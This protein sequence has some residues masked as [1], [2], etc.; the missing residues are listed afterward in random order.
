MARGEVAAAIEQKLRTGLAPDHIDIVDDSE[1][2]RGHSGWREG[3]E[4]HFRITIIANAFQGQ[5]R[6]ERHRAINRILAEELDGP[7]H[8]L[9]LR[10]LTPEERDA[11]NSRG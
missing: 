2:H 11:A 5:S 9:S 8:A 6:I 4:T 3:G 7:V 1:R 10:A